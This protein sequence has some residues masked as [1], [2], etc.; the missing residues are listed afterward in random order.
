MKTMRPPAADIR[1]RAGVA[2]EEGPVLHRLVNK[3]QCR[4]GARAELGDDLAVHFAEPC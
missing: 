4:L 3:R 1:D 2:E